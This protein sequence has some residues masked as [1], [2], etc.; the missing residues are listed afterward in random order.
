MAGTITLKDRFDVDSDAPL[1]EFDSPHAT[2]Y[3]CSDRMANNNDLI[4]LLCD[5]AVPVRIEAVD[6]LR[7]FPGYG[8]INYIDWGVVPWAPN[9]RR[10]AVVIMMRPGGGRVFKS[11]DAINEPM[12]DEFLI[13]GFLTPAA[14]TLKELSTR[15]LSHRAIRPTNLFYTSQDQRSIMFGEC[16]TAPPAIDQP[17]FIEPIESAMADVTARGEGGLLDDLFSLGVT[18]LF[19]VL[20][21]NPLGKTID[22]NKLLEDRISSG[23][24]TPIV[25]QNRI[26]MHI[27]ELLR[28][29]MSDD[30]RDRWGLRDIDLWIG[31]QRLTPK[32]PKLPMRARR[33]LVVGGR[34]YENIRS[35]AHALARNWPI[36]GE[37]IRGQDF[38]SWLRRSLPDDRV[39]A[40]VEKIA[41]NRATIESSAKGDEP[42]L[43]T[44]VSMALDTAAPIAHKGLAA[45]VDGIGPTLALHFN[46]ESMRQKVAEFINGRFVSQWMS[47]QTRT[48]PE[49]MQAYS[50]LERLPAVLLQTGPGFG[51]ERCLYELN[52]YMHCRSP[53]IEHLFVTKVE[54]LVPALEAV[55]QGSTVPPIPMD[56]HIAAFLV[57]RST[58]VDDR[59]LRPLAVKSDAPAAEA[60]AVLRILARVQ[61][62]QRNGP[63]AGL[64]AWM[65]SLLT[66]AVNAYHN[67]K[68]RRSVEANLT[69]ATD[70]GL[71]TELLKSVDDGK[72]V[73]RDEQGYARAKQEHQQCVSQITQ[74]TSDLQNKDVLASELGEQV[75]AVVSGVVASL[76]SSVIIIFFIA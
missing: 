62:L 45:H 21:K 42:K 52:P 37:I 13:K 73:Q 41:G 1:P 68:L 64:A 23:S 5:P 7:N 72:A 14:A 34:E 48:R 2:A 27:L 16:V 9:G 38:D 70:T 8:L 36:S 50:T 44:K 74:M 61:A 31:G 51:L 39:N 33:P 53:M 46:D 19:L 18:T 28:G 26:P 29:L 32:Q 76:G 47:L 40:S 43:V 65:A 67:L 30:P 4:A 54:E 57:A 71:L 58:D 22:Y 59:F 66:P 10:Q 55:A 75:A 12:T 49:L 3:A 60:I 69:L 20:G 6:S 24:Y 15:G 25:G 11:L 56:R 63:M 35:A 17:A